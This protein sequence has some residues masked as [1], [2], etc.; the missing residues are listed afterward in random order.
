M[1]KKIDAVI[2]HLSM[3]YPLIHSVDPSLAAFLIESGVDPCFAISWIL[4]W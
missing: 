2:Q 4:T 1:Q 3:L